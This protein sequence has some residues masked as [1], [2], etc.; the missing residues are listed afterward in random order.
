MP[1]CYEPAGEALL[2]IVI[3]F[4]ILVDIETRSET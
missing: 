3:A 4:R 2:I 1:L